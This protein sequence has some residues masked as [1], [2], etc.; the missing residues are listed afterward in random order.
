MKKTLL[1]IVLYLGLIGNQAEAVKISEYEQFEA[2][3]KDGAD[4]YISGVAV[5]IDYANSGSKYINKGSSD[6]V[7]Q[8][9]LPQGVSLGG[10]LAKVALQ[11][12]KD[13]EKGKDD[14]LAF[15][16][17]MGIIMMFPC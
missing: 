7:D 6:F 11:T 2:I 1:I 8:F 3:D 15:A 17:L 5:G 4:L 14:T 12:Y 9:C 13:A 10:N 16:V